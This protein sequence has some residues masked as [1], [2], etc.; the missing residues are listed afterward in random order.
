M[1]TLVIYLFLDR[2]LIGLSSALKDCLHSLISFFSD[3]AFHLS[4]QKIA[5]SLTCRVPT[6]VNCLRSVESVAGLDARSKHLRSVLAFQFLVACFDDKVHDEEQILRSLISINLKHKNCD[7]L[8]MYIQLV[9]AE[10]WLFCNPLLKDKPIISE[11]WSACLRNCSCQITSTDLRS[12]ASK[13]RSKA[14]YLLQG[15]ATR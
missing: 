13:V 1:I 15:S 10:N 11:T 7:L 9:L 5:K 6:D 8:K 14:S 4:C 3:D 12:Y 2:Q